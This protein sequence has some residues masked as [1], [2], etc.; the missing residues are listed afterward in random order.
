M[1]YR[2]RPEPQGP[3][4]SALPTS[5]GRVPPQA[6]D[7]EKAVLGA[8]LIDRE[9]V[10]KSL[11]VL[12]DAAFYSPL[13]QKI[14]RAMNALFDRSEPVDVV[15]VTEEMRK[16]G[17][18]DAGVD[19]LYL[20]ELTMNVSTSANV[21]YH[22]RIILEKFLM[23]SLIGSAGEMA[24]RAYNETEDALDLLDD[25]EAKIFSIS[26]RRMKKSFTPLRSALNETMETLQALHGTHGGITGVPSGFPRLDEKTG[27]FQKSDLIIVAGRPSQG[28]TALAL[29]MARNAA[30]H[31]DK[32][33]SV[34]IF[35]LEMAEQQLIIRLLA[36]EAKV[37]AHDLRTGRLHEDK[38]K[39]L[40]RN[41]GRLAEANIFID[42]TPALSILELRAKAR[43]LKAEHG[44]GLVIADYLQLIQGPRNAESR[45]REISMISRSLKALAKELNIPVIALSQL[46]RGVESRGD[47]RPMLADLRECVT[48]DTL[49]CLADGR[50]V[51]ISELVGLE[52]GVQT[53][54]P[55][56]R[57]GVAK[58][59]AVWRVGRRPV[60]EVRLASGRSIRAT[61]EHRLYGFDGWMKVRELKEGDRL[62][63]ARRIPEPE[64]VTAWPDE[65]LILLGHLIGDGSYLSGQPM[66]YTTSSVDNSHA[67]STS[68]EQGFGVTVKRYAGRNSWHQLLISGNGNRWHPEGV[69]KWLRGLGIFNQRSHEKRVPREIFS[70]PNNQVALFLKHLWAT[71]GCIHT[72]TGGSCISYYSTNSRELAF[73]VAS[74]L[75]RFGIVGRIGST[76]KGSYRPQY[77]VKITG[78]AQ[79]TTFLHEIGAF[80][81]RIHQ[82]KE[83]TEYISMRGAGTN[84]D[85]IPVE[86]FQRVKCLM[87]EYGI[88]QR[89]MSHLR[90][91]ANGGSSHFKFAPSR[92]VLLEYAE[93]LHNEDLIAVATSDLFWDTVTAIEPFGEEEVFDLTVPETSSWLAD[94]IVS[95]N[96][97]A[98]EQDADVVI[99]VHRPESYGITEIKDDEYGTIPSEGVAEII[100][101]KQRNG[102][103]DVVRL[104]FRKEYAG[105]ERLAPMGMEAMLPPPVSATEDTP[106]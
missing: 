45:E 32:R 104:A 18:L 47:K 23:R 13:H 64:S 89:E 54:H 36:A 24:S 101:G 21:E 31:K 92:V 11:E 4:L 19:P 106:F 98:I 103:T 20:T 61:A 73:D 1:A 43:R 39:N 102:P 40:S 105:F 12:D 74:L 56:G 85:T 28:K 27:G 15:T 69:N 93:L 96:S 26:E 84:V 42:D 78:R 99:F 44:I 57:I 14:Y 91:T 100:I 10:P 79:L 53:M 66:R 76:R 55:D 71:D 41:V 49:V 97:G 70:L 65:K 30:L 8:M 25:A 52:V 58:S 46:N 88:T 75:Q 62:A 2:K 68:A 80:G 63:I 83:L 87:R 6:V 67:V 3:D 22:A 17:T 35:S 90:G 51:P 86:V 33:T 5:G 37:N 48:G 95:H 34:A 7:V 94:G 16:M 59:D 29:T 82:T 50:R 9:A 60:F 77:H 72:R 81:P 38:W